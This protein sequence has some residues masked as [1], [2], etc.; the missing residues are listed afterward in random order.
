MDEAEG[1]VELG[2]GT[3]RPPV[4]ADGCARRRGLAIDADRRPPLKRSQ[5]ARITSTYSGSSSSAAQR[6]PVR[7]AA[8]RVEPDP[9]KMSRTS[10]PGRLL[11]AMARS[12]RASGFI[13]AC[14]GESDG[15]VDLPDVGLVARA[16]PVMRCALAPAI[17][18]W[19]VRALVGCPAQD[20]SIL[21]PDD[22]VAPVAARLGE[23][24]AQERPLLGTH[25]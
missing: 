4:G 22:R 25:A 2:S 17:P 14:S 9:A 7:S 20:E 8:I 12:M 15:P 6:R 13:V 23:N 1:P 18:D 19:L 5:R 3:A 24:A 16:A 11:L 10:A 21:G